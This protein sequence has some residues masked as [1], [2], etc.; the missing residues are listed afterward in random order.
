MPKNPDRNEWYFEECP[1]DEIDYCWTYEYARESE[2]LRTIIAKWRQ[3]AK[4]N[5]IEEYIALDE[6]IYAEPLGSAVYPFFPFWPNK[7]YLSI[8]PKTRNAWLDRLGM[9][10]EP[11]D[12]P[13]YQ[14]QARYWSK[15]STLKM[16]E[17][18]IMARSLSFRN[19]SSQWVVF[20]LDWNLHD[21]E[22]ATMF[23]RWLKENRPED[24]KAFEMRGRGNPARQGRAN[25]KYL[26]AYRL[27]K[28]MSRNDA[29]AFLEEEGG[30]LKPYRNYQDWDLALDRAKAIIQSLEDHTFIVP[31]DEE[32]LHGPIGE[33]LLKA[34]GLQCPLF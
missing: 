17:R 32:F 27:R 23:R 28:K 21:K 12:A 24:V 20:H 15:E 22:L 31:R 19:G 33:K 4:G 16:L 7:P 26:S 29:I 18:F 8:D 5:K 9:P 14:I 34:A 25:L 11:S 10:L 1:T 2:F 6:E 13:P 30:K 3:G